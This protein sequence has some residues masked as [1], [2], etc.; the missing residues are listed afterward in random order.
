MKGSLGLMLP[1]DRLA[2][3]DP[4]APLMRQKNGSFAPGV[5]VQAVLTWIRARSSTRSWWAGVTSGRG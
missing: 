3:T 2:V 4:D 5:N 1:Q